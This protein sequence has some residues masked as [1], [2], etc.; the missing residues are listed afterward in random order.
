MYSD[1]YAHK[2]LYAFLGLPLFLG[3][4][5]SVE[6]NKKAKKGFYAGAVSSYL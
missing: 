4:L 6:S 3:L 5:P 1:L 2:A